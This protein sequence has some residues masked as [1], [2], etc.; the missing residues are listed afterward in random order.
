[1]RKLLKSIMF[2]V[3]TVL[4]PTIVLASN[5]CTVGC[6]P[7]P[8][9]VLQ[10]G[11]GANFFTAGQCIQVNSGAN[12]FISI[13]CP[14]PHFMINIGLGFISGAVATSST[15]PYQQLP[16]YTNGTITKLRVACSIGDNTTTFKIQDVTSV[17]TIGTVTLSGSATQTVVLGTPYALTAGHVLNASVTTAGTATNCGVTAEGQVST[18]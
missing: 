11:T 18:F 1:M 3:A 8:L 15:Y 9:S 13:P 2:L 5:N 12:A 6:I 16:G 14:G 17:T 10:G 4:C 7:Q